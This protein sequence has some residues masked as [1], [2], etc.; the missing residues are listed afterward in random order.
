MLRRRWPRLAGAVFQ[1]SSL[2]YILRRRWLRLAGAVFQALSLAYAL[3]S[4][5]T[6]R[7]GRFQASSLTYMLRR[8]WLRLAGAVFKRRVGRRYAVEIARRR[9]ALGVLTL[10]IVILLNR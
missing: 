5:A 1:A 3:L 4:L 8:R 7:G 6:S 10:T 9:S 2:T